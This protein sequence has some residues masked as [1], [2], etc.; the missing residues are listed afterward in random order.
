MPDPLIAILVAGAI[1]LVGL[2][3]VLPKSGLL[4]R[5]RRAQRNN[6]RVLSE[7]ALKHIQHSETHGYPA[8]LHSLAGAL[9]IS[10]NQAAGILDKIQALN[11]VGI[12][13]NE[14]RLTPEGRE[15]ALRII[16]AHRL[17]ERYLAEET[18]FTEAEWHDQAEEYEHRLT[19]SEAQ[20]LASQL[21]NPLYDPHGDPIPT[22][23]GEFKP[24]QGKP[25]PSMEIDA[26]LRI[27][28]I[29]D[30]PEVIYAQLVAEGLHPGMEARIL[31]KSPQRV[32]FFAG[33]D[34]HLLA[35]I[36]AG[37]ISVLPVSQEP[38]ES[39]QVGQPL[40]ELKA[41]QQGSVL[42]LSPRI[43]GAE[44]RRLMDLGILPGVVIEAAFTSPSGDPT[45]Y[46]VRETLIALRKEQA[47]SILIS[48]E[49]S[50]HSEV[51]VKD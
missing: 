39:R 24:H 42:S 23:A 44:R 4:P 41:G 40:S 21:G 3:L 26:P 10:V 28:H 47:R 11:L 17:W 9:N 48:Q 50:S 29:E 34:V 8:N 36:V 49:R 19:D 20:A 6:E 46:R 37:N 5:W 14:F 35:P 45:A 51:D 12:E 33:G 38:V 31:E 32:R 25:L 13:G 18:G 2:G 22:N 7:D 30:E 1:I 16:R 15:Y 27:V 43:R